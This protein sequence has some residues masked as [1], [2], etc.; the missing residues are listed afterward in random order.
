MVFGTSEEFTVLRKVESLTCF[1][2]AE[3]LKNELLHRGGSLCN[4]VNLLKPTA[5]CTLNG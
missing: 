2:N 3:L 4:S 5:L 1:L